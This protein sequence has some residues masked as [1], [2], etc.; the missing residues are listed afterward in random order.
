MRRVLIQQHQA[1]GASKHKIRAGKLP[2]IR[3]MVKRNSFFTGGVL[4]VA[5]NV[6]FPGAGEQIPAN[7]LLQ[8]LP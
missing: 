2:E 3:S 8:I 4:N 5:G 7:G 6:R 1:A